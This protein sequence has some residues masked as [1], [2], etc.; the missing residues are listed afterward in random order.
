MTGAE[1]KTF[2]E[3]QGMTPATFAGFLGLRAKDAQRSVYNWE[4][5][6]VRVPDAV[7][8]LVRLAERLPSAR[9]LL[10]GE[11]SRE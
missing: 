8:Q 1:L 5:G 2:R 9:L 10:A 11:L 6:S 4:G 3:R 7:A